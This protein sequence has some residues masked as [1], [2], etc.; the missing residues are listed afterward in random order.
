MFLE[1]AMS[2]RSRQAHYELKSREAE[3][4]AAKTKDPET[5]DEWLKIAESYRELAKGTGGGYGPE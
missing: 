2:R 3:E 5:R 4:M 1:R